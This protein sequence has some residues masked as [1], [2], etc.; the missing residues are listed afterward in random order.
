MEVGFQAEQVL[1]EFW[2]VRSGISVG[3]ALACAV[4]AG[5]RWVVKK[6]GLDW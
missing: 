1:R 4:L 2:R 3:R 5:K 6:N